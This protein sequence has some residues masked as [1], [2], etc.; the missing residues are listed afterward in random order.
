MKFICSQLALA[1]ALNTV[2]KA[3][4]TRTTIPI[5]KGILLTVQKEHLI[6]TASD[7]DLSIETTVEVNDAE[8]GSVVVSARLFGDIIRRLPNAPVKVDMDEKNNLR[9]SCLSS[10]F[11]I[12]ALPADEFPSI[13]SVKEEESLLIQKEALKELIKKT[14]FSASIDEKKGILTGCLLEM[15]EKE[16]VMVSLDGFR[17]AVATEKIAEKAKR[18]IVVPARILNE[19]NKLIGESIQEEEITVLLDEKKMEIKTADTRVISRLMEGEFIKYADIIPKNYK[20]RCVLERAEMLNSI[21]RASLL[22]KEGKNNLIKVHLQEGTLEITSRSEEGNVRE[23]LSCETEGEEIVIG[24]N[25]KYIA[26]VLKAVGE[27]EVV[28]EMSGSTSPCLIKPLEG[29]AFLYLVLP[30]RIAAS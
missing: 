18:N 22:A 13:G 16:V 19:I 3:V 28:F 27:E 14:T 12:V 7:L 2:S 23:Q 11:S 20:S 10:D 25:S 6:L 30:V 26:D 17:M 8:E 21:E 1:K 4:S 15:K 24:F 29:N 9:I 5:L